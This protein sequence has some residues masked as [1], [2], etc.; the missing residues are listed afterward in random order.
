MLWNWS[1]VLCSRADE[2]SAF[3]L[4]DRVSNPSNCSTKGK[5]RKRCALREAEAVADSSKSE[6]KI[7]L[8]PKHL[9]ARLDHRINESRFRWIPL[10]HEKTQEVRCSGVTLRAKWVTK[11]GT[12]SPRRN[13]SAI[14]VCGRLV[15]LR[16]LSS[17]E[18]LSVCPP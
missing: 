15:D 13:R 12:G 18:A 7:W 4:F 11:P 3:I 9:S 14:T 2:V 6:I 5:K 10:E 17:S 1:N 8:L 16:D